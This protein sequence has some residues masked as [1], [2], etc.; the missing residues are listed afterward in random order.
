MLP[1]VS[2]LPHF[3]RMTIEVGQ[4]LTFPVTNPKR[5]E[6]E[7]YVGYRFVQNGNT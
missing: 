5:K 1:S 7:E 2:G 6:E 4:T 3:A